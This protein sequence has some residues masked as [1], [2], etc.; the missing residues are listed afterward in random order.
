MF[1]G[2]DVATLPR[3]Q[4]RM[5]LRA[6]NLIKEKRC[7]KLKARICANGSKQKKYLS[8]DES[9]A[10]PTSSNEGV[11]TSFMIDAYER[12]VIAILDIPGAYLHAKMKHTNRR[13]LMKMQGQFVCE[14][15]P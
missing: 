13:I 14:A 6:I 9:V 8:P 3:K 12:R 15:D 1:E 4:R 7:G 11:L 2:A 5:A 10:S